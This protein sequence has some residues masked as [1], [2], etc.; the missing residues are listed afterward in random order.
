VR[1][2]AWKNTKQVV[3]ASAIAFGALGCVLVTLILHPRIAPRWVPDAASIHEEY[4]PPARAG[5]DPRVAIGY[6]SSPTPAPVAGRGDEGVW[7]IP[8]NPQEL[9]AFVGSLRA[10]GHDRLLFSSNAEFDFEDSRIIEILRGLEGDWVVPELGRLAVGETDPLLKAVLVTGLC[11]G[12]ARQ[13]LDDPRMIEQIGLLLPQL[14]AATEDAFHVG[15]F[16]VFS[17]FCACL[18]QKVDYQALVLPAL[19]GADNPDVLVRGYMFLGR[20][21]GAEDLLATVVREHESA[22]GRF[23]ALEGLRD[24]ALKGRI[25]S[26]DLARIGL[27]ALR[28]ETSVRNRVLL[29]EMV[30]TAGGEEGMQALKSM[31]A[32]GEPG[33]AGPAASLIAVR[34]DPERA[35]EVLEQAL[36]SATLSEK[37]R[38]S[39]YQALGA[40]D[41]GRGSK[42]LLQAVNDAELPERERL[43][44][45][46]GFW[47]RPVDAQL[48]EELAT[49]LEGDQPGALRAESMRLLAFSEGGSPI[50]ARSVAEGD[51]DPLVR[52]EAVLLRAMEPGTATNEW[53]RQRFL[54]DDSDDVRA[55]ALGAMVVQ[56]RYTGDAEST[57][58]LLDYVKGTTD[59][60]AIQSLVARGE[61]MLGEY[62]P[63][64]VDLELRKDVEF[65]R[66]IARFTTGAARVGMERQAAYLQKM[67]DAIAS[68]KRPQ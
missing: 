49:I 8:S 41:D 16:V 65:Y 66:D 45:L 67:V 56:A 52:K 28:T 21:P 34:M 10:L 1:S 47:N 27:D 44:A 30:A 50:D 63:R 35:Q 11:N 53:L 46:R 20:S 60:P 22:E 32:K 6:G 19:E 39:V 68:L 54:A 37:D 61:K 33:L 40:V 48:R 38:A 62:D 17:A 25:P 5:S 55:A 29:L 58:G 12:A 51:K 23:G 59:D 2:V 24:A 43:D 31:L 36:A 64:R 26:Q 18:C 13:R 9:R 14:S 57:R 3:I 42:R 4:A 15:R 7:P